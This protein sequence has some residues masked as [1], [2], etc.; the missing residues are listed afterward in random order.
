MAMRVSLL[1]IPFLAITT[2]SFDFDSYEQFLVQNKG[3]QAST[4][5]EK[6]KPGNP[7]FSEIISGKN[8][9]YLDSIRQ[10]YG[11]TD[12]ELDILKRNN[13]VV[14]ERKSFG[15][16][17]EALR[18]IFNKD[19]P[20]FL[21]TDAI[22]YTLHL[23]Y[24]AILAS[25]EKKY[26]EPSIKEIVTQ[27]RGSFTDLITKYVNSGIDRNLADIDLYLAIAE[28]MI[29]GTKASPTL[30]SK[31]TFD[32]VYNAIQEE[33]M[34]QMK[35]FS[36]SSR[37]LD[38]SQFTVRGHY[39]KENL[40][41]YFKTMIWLG[42][43]EFIIIPPKQGNHITEIKDDNRRMAIDAIL[44][45]EL[46]G[47]SGKMSLFD[48]MDRLLSFLVG[49]SDNLIIDEFLATLDAHKIDR[50]EKLLSDSIFKSLSSVLSEMPEAG[51]KILSQLVMPDPFVKDTLQLPV[52]YVFFGQRFIVDSY[53]FG[54]V[55]YD[56]ILHNG[57]KVPRLMPD[58]LDVMYALGNSDA[59]PLL[60]KELERYF[61]APQ[62]ETMRYLLASYEQSFWRSTAYNSWLNILKQLNPGAYPETNKQPLFMRSTAWH[63]KTLNT[64]LASWAQLRH[65]NMLYAKQSYSPM[66]WC[67]YPHGYV[68]PYP[69]F[70]E[71]IAKLSRSGSDKLK[72]MESLQRVNSYFVWVADIMDSLKI[73]AE[74][75]LE[76]QPFTQQ[77]SLFMSRMLIVQSGC[78]KK[79]AE[80]WFG[81]LIYGDE[82]FGSLYR[83]GS[84]ADSCDY[85]IADVHTQPTDEGGA[86]V[87]KVLHTGVGK[88]NL[89]VFLAESPS[90]EF[91]PMAYAG[92]VVSYYQKVTDDFKRLTDEEWA[93][94]VTKD[95]VPDRPDWVNCFL[96]DSKGVSLPAGR[97]LDGIK[98]VT[99]VLPR[100]VNAQLPAFS[101]KVN[102]NMISLTLSSVSE[103]QISICD[104]R[105]KVIDKVTK[106]FERGIH[107]I[108]FPSA[109]GMY[110][111][112]VKCN[113]K[114]LTVKVGNISN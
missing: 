94:M 81:T 1:A 63:Q 23:S 48:D 96:A 55:I 70:Y 84:Q 30:V 64:Q 41:N 3:L 46:L 11:L 110:T 7:Y 80:G 25:V 100:K 109:S 104:L 107:Q 53:V 42:R 40:Q 39:S 69:S 33:K 113:G 10:K 82:W 28:S 73:L 13:F 57:Q 21:T 59:A 56:K 79:I 74:K 43:T 71:E 51:Q 85:T 76:K 6:A 19:L 111:A 27:M 15:T 87:G 16:F 91:K 24:D 90:A 66:T 72:N 52:S 50:A 88:I 97:V 98:Y 95:S 38:F 12:A 103:I 45:S 2:F 67:S 17:G 112:V 32:S 29:N 47:L 78:D 77:D 4:M 92:P 34:V 83:G 99:R 93:D 86:I 31:A 68:E 8:Y 114:T 60:R 61:Y 37:Y 5:V 75:E 102:G 26:F 105:G 44:L 101:A 54:N 65:D 58:P 22:L 89:G 14:T 49:E 36:D 62:L 35:L 108:T 9:L 18:D 20:V 106:S